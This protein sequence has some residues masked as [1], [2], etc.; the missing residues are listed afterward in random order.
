MSYKKVKLN[1]NT[2]MRTTSMEVAYYLYSVSSFIKGGII[3]IWCEHYEVN[4]YN[5]WTVMYVYPLKTPINQ[6]N[7]LD[8]ALGNYRMEIRKD[9]SGIYCFKLQGCRKF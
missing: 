5:I 3:C 4:I 8:R 2:G 9:Y 1:Y 6:E 7:L